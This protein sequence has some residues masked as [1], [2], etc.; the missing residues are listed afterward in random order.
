MSALEEEGN[1]AQHGGVPTALGDELLP[2]VHRFP[3]QQSEHVHRAQHDVTTRRAEGAEVGPGRLRR[4]PPEDQSIGT[5]ALGP[6]QTVQDDLHTVR[7][8][9]DDIRGADVQETVRP[10]NAENGSNQRQQKDHVLL[11]GNRRPNPA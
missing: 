3:A 5:N 4:Q 6:L 1:A 10:G 8:D 11:R 2:R 9:V 7:A